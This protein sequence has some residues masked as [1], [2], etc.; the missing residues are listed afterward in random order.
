M[1]IIC[2]IF[3]FHFFSSLV[4]LF[5]FYEASHLFLW[6][7]NVNFCKYL[8]FVRLFFS[9]H[10]QLVCSIKYVRS[11]L[12]FIRS[13]YILCWRKDANV[14]SRCLSVNELN[15]N[16]VP[17]FKKERTNE[18][19][20]N[21]LLTRSLIRQ[22]SIEC[23]AFSTLTK[24]ARMKKKTREE[25]SHANWMNI[26]YKWMSWFSYRTVYGFSRLYVD[27]AC[28]HTSFNSTNPMWIACSFGFLYS[29]AWCDLIL[30]I[31]AWVFSA[32]CCTH[33]HMHAFTKF[34]NTFTKLY[35][36]SKILQNKTTTTQ[37]ERERVNDG[38]NDDDISIRETNTT[39]ISSS[40]KSSSGNHH[41]HIHVNANIRLH[42]SL[43]KVYFP[44]FS[45]ISRDLDVIVMLVVV[46][47][48]G[49]SFHT[50]ESNILW[51][52]CLSSHFISTV[53]HFLWYFNTKYTKINVHV[54][55]VKC[56]FRSFS[57]N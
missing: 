6:I 38:C 55:I 12:L 10:I 21:S 24:C 3:R 47:D 23:A 31:S 50:F 16:Q 56:I 32:R 34:Y 42:L 33:T 51:I 44:I 4:C 49:D 29:S 7:F 40:N 35:G 8:S 27:I 30:W 15:S 46:S 22:Y 43:D 13:F 37:R 41:P 39:S 54:C 14:L 26:N 25:L 11:K 53:E 48:L 20:Q 45:F 57:N 19:K 28:A 52:K 18:S 1:W 5:G 9:S 2:F 17:R 36:I